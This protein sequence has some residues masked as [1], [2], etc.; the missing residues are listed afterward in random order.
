MT[1]GDLV[2]DA[3]TSRV[4]RE[5]AVKSR[6]IADGTIRAEDLAD[7]VLVLHALIVLFIVGGFLL[8]LI[9]RV[10]DWRWISNRAFRR[11]HLAAIAVVVL[12]AWA[13][14]LCPLTS[15]ES[16]LRIRGG[17]SPYSETF[18]QHWLHQFLFFDAPMWVFAVAYTLFGVVAVAVFILDQRH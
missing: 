5:D 17:A 8:I 10:R 13:G 3:V 14:R 18:I 4:L 11:I 9:G 15:L 6:H 12:Q 7:G 2:N 1:T 16:A